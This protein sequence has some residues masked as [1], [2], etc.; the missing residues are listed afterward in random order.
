M[1]SPEEALFPDGTEPWMIEDRCLA[2]KLV[3]EDEWLVIMP[4]MFSVRL[5]VANKGNASIEHWCYSSVTEA[6]VA[7][8]LYPEVL[9][10]W[11]RHQRRDRT[12]ERPEGYIP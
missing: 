6:L 8:A 2:G 4:M 11:K 12:M 5:A 9:T 7:W 1:D 10:S 3:G